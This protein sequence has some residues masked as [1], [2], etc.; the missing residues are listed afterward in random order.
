MN[1]SRPY[2][3]MALVHPQAS[4]KERDEVESSVRAWVEER[5]GTVMTVTHDQKRRLA[6]PIRHVQQA[7][8]TTMRFQLPA[9]DLTDLQNRLGRQKKVLR[10]VIFQQEPRAEVKTLK[11]VPLRPLS[12]EPE[13][14]P[15]AAPKKE[16][17]SIE[18][19]DEKIEEILGEEVL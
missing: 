10:F 19:L 12:A 14:T 3:L 8:A 18:K 6:Y 13:K 4:T 16:K 15:V 5:S 1:D 2:I 17:A 11:D 7:T 9:Q